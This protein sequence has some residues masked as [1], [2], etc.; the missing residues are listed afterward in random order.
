MATSATMRP[1]TSPCTLSSTTYPLPPPPGSSASA[2]PMP[3]SSLINLSNLEHFL[4]N[5]NTR[6]QQQETQIA[7]LQ[8]TLTNSISLT[9]FSAFSS[10]LLTHIEEQEQKI[11]QLQQQIQTLTTET[12]HIQTHSKTLTQQQEI[13]KQTVNQQTLSSALQAVEDRLSDRI[14]GLKKDK[15]TNH[16]VNHL[17]SSQHLLMSQLTSLQSLL[18]HKIDRAELPLLDAANDKFSVLLDYQQSS[19][20]RIERIEASLEA[21]DHTLTEKEDK[22]AINDKLSVLSDDVANKVDMSWLEQN[23][24]DALT[25]MQDELLRFAAHD[26]TMRAIIEEQ[27]QIHHTVTHHNS[28]VTNVSTDV[29]TTAEKLQQLEKTVRLTH[30]LHIYTV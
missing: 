15:A 12:T 17:E 13:L 19:Q 3:M 25:D 4:T 9:A 14:D 10:T 30:T 6:L 29:T 2:S 7:A 20:Q 26:E 27:Q 1:A 11:N 28:H 8:Q 16:Q 23:V 22:T 5:I 18:S 21:I 24:L